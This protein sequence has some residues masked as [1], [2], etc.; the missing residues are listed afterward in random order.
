MGGADGWVES[1]IV[2]VEV[3]VEVGEIQGRCLYGVWFLVGGVDLVMN[4]G[5]IWSL[6]LETS[7]LG[8]SPVTSD[9][10]NRPRTAPRIISPDLW[11]LVPG[12]RT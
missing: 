3:G 11:I 2:E 4:K 7:P 5:C 1:V 10:L 6:V 9:Q 8:A 12:L